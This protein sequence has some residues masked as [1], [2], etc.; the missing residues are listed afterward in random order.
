MKT[1]FEPSRTDSNAPAINQYAIMPLG[2]MRQLIGLENY[3]IFLPSLLV[4]I[5]LH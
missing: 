5:L 4:S 3:L 2:I 1:E